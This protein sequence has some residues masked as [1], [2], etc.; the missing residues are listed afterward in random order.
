MSRIIQ[1]I[2]TKAVSSDD[3]YQDIRPYHDHEV[4]D[5][6]KRLA[7]DQRLISALAQ[8][9]FPRLNRFLSVFTHYVIRRYLNGY[10]QKV[11]GVHDV[12]MRLASYIERSIQTSTDSF[13]YEGLGQ[14]DPN[15][16]YLFI[17]N[18]RD[19]VMDPTF[20][21]Y[22]L[23]LEGFPTARIAAGD[24]LLSEQ[25]IEDLMRLNKTFIVKRSVSNRREKLASLTLLSEYIASSIKDDCSIWIAHREGRSKDGID[26]TD[27]AVLKMLQLGLRQQT[28]SFASAMQHLH[29][30]PVA[31][32][33]QY[34]PCDA[35]KAHELAVKAQTGDYQKA[36]G[37]DTH[38]I[39][40]GIMG[41]KGQVHVAFGQPLSQFS[42]DAGE[43]A[44]IIDQAIHQLY[45]LHDTNYAAAD[46]LQGKPCEALNA[47]ALKHIQGRLTGL[48]ESER[49][50]LLGMYA[51]P[52]LQ[53]QL[54][55]S[56]MAVCDQ[57]V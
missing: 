12:Q 13:T 11:K 29:I 26:Q 33:Y 19:I 49:Q 20:V 16:A 7:N 25:Y 22:A 52:V 40:T 2:M 56:T 47:E 44:L 3:I 21:N 31:I 35:M 53:K 4:P 17:S 43:M 37:E 46:L 55:E 9:K 6:L 18:H 39:V 32:S 10:V 15:Q 8:F 41:H 28:K 30:V 42:E 45:R 54:S 1:T 38:S 5:V 57:A 23:H 14:L 36:P 48:V 51:N 50:Q 24:N 27:S 34:D